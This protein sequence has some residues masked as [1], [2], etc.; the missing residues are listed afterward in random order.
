MMWNVNRVVAVRFAYPAKT[1]C[2][3]QRKW[4]EG[5]ARLAAAKLPRTRS[6]EIYACPFAE[7]GGF[8]A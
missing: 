7:L 1:E 8:S 4:A 6:A 2:T 5:S 3:V